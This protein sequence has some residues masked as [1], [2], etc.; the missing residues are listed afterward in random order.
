VI[1]AGDSVG[2]ATALFAA[3]GLMLIGA[4]AWRTSVVRR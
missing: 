4:I 1:T 2:L 3:G